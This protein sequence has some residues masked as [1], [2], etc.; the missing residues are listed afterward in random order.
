[1]KEKQADPT[2]GEP[3]VYCAKHTRLFR[4]LSDDPD[5]QSNLTCMNGREDD[6]DEDC[7]EVQMLG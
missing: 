7:V 4:D 1:M 6:E 3:R 2:T 5:M